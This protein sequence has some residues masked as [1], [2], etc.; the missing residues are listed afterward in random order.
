MAE[1]GYYGLELVAKHLNEYF[2]NL[3]EV[4]HKNGGDLYKIAGDACIVPILQKFSI[5]R[6]CLEAA[7]RRGP[8]M[9]SACARCSARWTY[10]ARP[11]NRTIKTTSRS[12][13]TLVALFGAENEGVG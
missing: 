8:S 5:F 11:C 7:P 3:I 1:R 12:P 6:Q 13:C 2:G 4:L 9:S 10:R